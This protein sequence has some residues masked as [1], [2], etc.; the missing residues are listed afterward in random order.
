MTARSVVLTS[1]LLALLGLLA[2]AIGN[3]RAQEEDLEAKIKESADRATE[4]LLGQQKNGQWYHLAAGG[5]PENNWGCT[6]LVGLGLLVT[7]PKRCD[8]AIR[9]AEAVILTNQG[10]MDSTYAIASS[11]LFLQRRG[12]PVATLASKLVAG[13]LSDGGWSYSCSNKQAI[14]D[15]SNTHFAVLALL[16]ARRAQSS[17]G[18]DGA[19]RKA[20]RHFR[21]SQQQDGGWIYTRVGANQKTTLSMTCVGL[22]GLAVSLD[23]TRKNY[24]VTMKGAQAGTKAEKAQAD[25]M[26]EM[27]KFNNDPQVI[28]AR[29]YILGQLNTIDRSTE[30]LT[31]VLWS[32]ERIAFIYGEKS[33]FKDYD[34]Y[35]MGSRVLMGM[36]RA[37]G[38]WDQ[39]YRQGPNVD[40]CMSLLFLR[41]VNLL[42]GLNMN[43]ALVGRDNLRDRTVK[44][45]T[46]RVPTG[47]KGTPAEAAALLKEL[48]TAIGP[49][50]DEIMKAFEIHTDTA[51]R[52]ALL[53]V[54]MSD[55]FKASMKERARRA[56]ANRMANLAPEKLAQYMVEPDANLRL[57]A[58]VGASIADYRELLP[59]LIDKLTDSDSTVAAAAHEVLKAMTKQDHGRTPDAWKRWY[60]ANKN[61]ADKK[62]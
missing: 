28:K 23:F 57:A 44:G 40:T 39:D 48:E 54:L 41:R 4:Y 49:R 47:P 9:D 2:V 6:A 29:D 62:P 38:S 37:D 55:K 16:I 50:V 52:E 14:S 19:L 15:N 24:E 36:Q 22:L 31:Y 43:V 5:S 27:Q 21:Q 34:W 26:R 51:Y 25:L 30:H 42:D 56:L 35:A 1:T 17:S 59:N 32:L 46:K 13:Q 60:E 3:A 58:V 20:E 33:F 10:K 45:P 12:K 61:K 53:D 11:L 18:V 8:R 7:D